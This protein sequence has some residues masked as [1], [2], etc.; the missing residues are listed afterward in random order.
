M[1]C[2]RGNRRGI[3]GLYTYLLCSQLLSNQLRSKHGP[4]WLLLFVIESEPEIRIRVKVCLFCGIAES[5]NEKR[6]ARCSLIMTLVALLPLGGFSGEAKNF[7]AA[8]RH[9]GVAADRKGREK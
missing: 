9:G 4:F 2:K 1:R 5:S 6:V 7:P 3:K 8:R